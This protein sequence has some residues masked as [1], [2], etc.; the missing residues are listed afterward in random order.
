MPD[1][2]EDVR[3]H[4]DHWGVALLERTHTRYSQT[5]FGMRGEQ[6]VVLKVG[7]A[8]ARRREATALR[9]YTDL[10]P[11]PA[12]AAD[13]TGP[14]Q[15]RAGVAGAESLPVACRLL[16]EA[17]GALLL[18]RIL[19]GDDLRPL[20][21][22]DDD[23]ATAIAGTVYARMHAA[24][25]EVA[26]PAE[27]PALTQ[28]QQT[29]DEYWRRDD[30]H[31]AAPPLPAELVRRAQAI[32]ADLA[33]P[34]AD[35]TVLHGD[36]HHQNLLRHGLGDSDDTWRIIDPHGW[37]GDPTF[38]AVVLML[39]L[40]GSLAMS[41]RN[42][43]DLRAQ[44]HRRA[45]ILAETAGLDPARLLAWTFA[46]G[47]IAELWCLSDHGFVQGGPLRLAEALLADT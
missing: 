7:D 1:P 35:D 29:F 38:D 22:V 12:E 30:A 15:A 33:A 8:P 27:L 34:T 24:V 37:W 23:A 11:T 21:A 13:A 45:A 32:A 31:G 36:A 2:P 40:H 47:V 46:G 26:R 18:E 20:A 28:L 17:D 25:A 42:H 43:D 4:A 44:A 41:Q 6:H 19:L 10:G 5:W 14:G 39:N 3:R 9:A 16:V